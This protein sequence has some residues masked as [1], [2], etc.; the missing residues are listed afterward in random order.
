MR[1]GVGTTARALAEQAQ[2]GER[3]SG[4]AERLTRLVTQVSAAMA[5]QAAA[6]EQITTSVTQMR[7]EAD[8]M[9]RAMSEQARAMR[10]ISTASQSVGKEIATIMRA[11]QEHSAAAVAIAT[12]LAEIRAITDR[13]VAGV[14]V[15]R[16]ATAG[17]LQRARDLDMRAERLNGNGRGSH[18]R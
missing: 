16:Q 3:I 5:E 17:L 10:D 15:M 7:R 14:N 2:S 6:A 9:A 4:E 8:Q 12:S 11:N 1:R 13:N 18:A